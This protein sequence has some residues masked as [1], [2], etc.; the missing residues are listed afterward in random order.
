MQKVNDIDQAKA[1]ALQEFR[2]IYPYGLKVRIN[3]Q[4]QTD[5]WIVRISW[6]SPLREAEYR[7]DAMTGYVRKIS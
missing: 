3:V 1:L 7:V 6:G 5:I 4:K 2:K